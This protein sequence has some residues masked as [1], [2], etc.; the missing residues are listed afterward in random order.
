MY[1]DILNRMRICVRLCGYVMTLHAEEEMDEDALTIFDIEHC[2]LTG[3]IVERQRDRMTG[4]RKYL[5]QGGSMLGEP[6]V[7]VGK[8]SSADKLVIITVYRA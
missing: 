4:V 1:E 2:I 7:V 8:M 3:H 6:L 5:V